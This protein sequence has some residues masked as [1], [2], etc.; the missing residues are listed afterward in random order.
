MIGIPFSGNRP[1]RVNLLRMNPTHH[2]SP[3]LLKSVLSLAFLCAPVK[4]EKPLHV[5]PADLEV[6]LSFRN[7]LFSGFLF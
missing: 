6:I 2:Q 3:L 7:R 1:F 5:P 4:K